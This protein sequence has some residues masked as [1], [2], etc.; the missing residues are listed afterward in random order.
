MKQFK[1]KLT[2]MMRMNNNF[3]NHRRLDSLAF[4]FFVL[5]V[6]LFFSPTLALSAWVEYSNAEYLNLDGESG[7]EIILTS[8][9]G[10]GSNHYVEDMRIYKDLY[11]ELKLIFSVKT[12]DSNYGFASPS[13]YNYNEVSGVKFSDPNNK[14]GAR[15]IIVETRK[16]Y[17]KDSE[18]K[19]SD[20]EE[21]ARKE[22]FTWNGINF[23]KNEQRF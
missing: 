14:T 10:V 13:P 23:I 7:D 20:K 22:I 9:H 8:K 15:D 17:F 1:R 5:S 11:P 2:R 19:S 6:T 21:K 3:S 16:I 18:N 12:L 4:I